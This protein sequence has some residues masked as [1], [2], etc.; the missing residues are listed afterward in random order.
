MKGKSWLRRQAA[1]LTPIISAAEGARNQGFV[2]LR[3]VLMEQRGFLQMVQSAAVMTRNMLMGK[4]TR[5]GGLMSPR[6]A[7]VPVQGVQLRAAGQSLCAIKHRGG[8]GELPDDL[9]EG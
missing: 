8:G 7:G 9:S 5:L 2:R 3:V 1:Y 6:L 4:W